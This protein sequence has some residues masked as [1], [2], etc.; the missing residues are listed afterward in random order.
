MMIRRKKISKF[1]SS[2]DIVVIEEN[3][4]N[5]GL[6]GSGGDGYRPYTYEQ[7]ANL[8][9]FADIRTKVIILLMCSSG[10]RVGALPLLK[11][12]DLIAV[13]KYNIYQIRVYANSKSNR[14]YTFC[15]PECTKAIDNY[16]EFRRSCGENITPESPL[17]RQEFDRDDIFQVAN[18]IRPLTKFAIR[19]ALTKVLYASGLRTPSVTT[20]KKLNTRRETAMSH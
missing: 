15:T 4:N 6:S 14:Y 8:L 2:D 16:M 3:S 19:K 5:S 12:G 13:P 18:D 17:L 1:L 7:I 9:E 11:V 10:M 20:A